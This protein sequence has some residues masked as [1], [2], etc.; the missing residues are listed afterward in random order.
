MVLKCGFIENNVNFML[1]IPKKQK[2]KKQQKGH[3]FSKIN[4]PKS[5]FFLTY[6]QF[7]LKASE[8]G[9]ISSK[10]LESFYHRLNKIIKKAGRVFILLFPTIAVSKKPIEVRMGKGKGNV[11]H[12]IARVR[13]GTPICE[14]ITSS[15][16]LGLKALN[17]AKICLPLKTKIFF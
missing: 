17:N 13:P 15:K 10:Q 12:W 1:F 6:G 16:E 8:V 4:A 5:L 11:S 2:Y 3:N 9:R 14:I 7:G